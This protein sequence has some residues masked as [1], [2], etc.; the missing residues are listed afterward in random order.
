MELRH[1]RYFVRAAELLHFT[2]AAES[3]YISQPTLSTHIQQLEEEIGAPLF[4]RVGRN[5]RLTQAGCAFLIHA[6]QVSKE[7]EV[8]KAEIAELSGL[9]TGTLR[10][11]ALPLFGQELLPTWLAGFHAQYPQIQ[12][13]AK[14]GPHQQFEKELLA[15]E[16]DLALTFLST[17]SDGLDS[18]LLFSDQACFIVADNHPMAKKETIRLKDVCSVPLATGN[19]LSPA[20]KQFD[21]ACIEKK[22]TP[23]IMVEM[24]D[25]RGILEIVKRGNAGTVLVTRVLKDHT[26]LKDFP[27]QDAQM[28]IEFGVLWRSQ[29]K[30]SPPAK[31]FFAYI[32]KNFGI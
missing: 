6:L 9:L 16:I 8:A 12:I 26:G 19:K 17:E 5:V 25:I 32:K 29:G 18:Q 7:L 3:L 20:R 31:A 10:L 24:N 15:G 4:D 1:I 11:A 27:I 23:N 30:L 13:S 14:A 28:Q 22:L 2:H 21:Q